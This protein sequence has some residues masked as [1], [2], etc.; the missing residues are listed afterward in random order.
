M[1][2]LEN[3]FLD[4]VF[5]LFS[6]ERII[7]ILFYGTN[8]FNRSESKF[9]DYDFYIMLDKYFKEDDILIK[10]LAS[11]FPD[12]IM[13]ITYQYLEDLEKIG[14]QSYQLGNH[15]VFYMLNFA[16]SI[17]LYGYNIFQRKLIL[18]DNEKLRESILFQIQEYF[19]RLDNWF[20]KEN[21]N[22][23]LYSKY[24]KYIIRIL[25][26]ILLFNGDISFQEI[27]VK[28]YKEIIQLI[29]LKP[30]ISNETKQKLK[31]LYF[32]DN[33]TDIYEFR[34]LKRLIYEDYL[35]LLPK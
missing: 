2:K 16:Q 6:K 10:K 34:E 24:K 7:C 8:A 17:L 4:K 1:V 22:A 35:I 13:D 26:D 3:L 11:S 21:E 32:V 27:N 19:W 12:K 23:L 25:V 31:E 15:G 20:L 30:Y 5:S 28:L 9:S 33:A 18:I 14:W 29:K